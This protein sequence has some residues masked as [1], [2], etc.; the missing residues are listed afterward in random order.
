M[1]IL[2]LWVLAKPGGQPQPNLLPSTYRGLTSNRQYRNPINQNVGSKYTGWPSISGIDYLSVYII[3]ILY[4]IIRKCSISWRKKAW[5]FFP[6]FFANIASTSTMSLNNLFND[7]VLF[8]VYWIF[9]HIS[10]YH[11]QWIYVWIGAHH[12][13]GI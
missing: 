13:T 4:R 12:R 3:C 2:R 6:G 5:E 8:F 9:L 1:S 7:F 10:P 11:R